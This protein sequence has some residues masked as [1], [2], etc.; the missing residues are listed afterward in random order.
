M[1][2]RFLLGPAGSGKTHHC[3]T[4]LRDLE[5]AGLAGI[6]LVPE[7]FTYSADRE[8]LE[9]PDLRG[10]RHVR[11]LSFTRL[12]W[13]IRE[14]CGERPLRT[15]DPAVRPMILRSVMERM[16][17]AALGPLAP[18]RGRAGVL[19][20]LSRF[21][22]EVRN[23]GPLD[24]FDG[25]RAGQ[26]KSI[27]ETAPTAIL[28]K[29][30]ALGEVYSAY[31]AR[32]SEMGRR[33]PEEHLFGLEPLLA[34]DSSWSALTFYVDGFLSWTRREVELLTVLAKRDARIEIA[35]CCDPA[36][37]SDPR[38][39][40]RPVF[41]SLEQ[42]ESR[43]SR[44]GV[45]L[46]PPVR[47]PA[48]D[49]PT[50]FRSPALRLLERR[51]YYTSAL[52]LPDPDARLPN[53][54]PPSHRASPHQPSDS[55]SSQPPPL[56]ASPQPPAVT[57][58][59]TRDRRQEVVFWARQIDRWIRLEAEPIERHEIAVL[60]RD[61]E[62][63]RDLVHEIFE[64]YEIPYFIDERR[65]V[66]AHPRVRLLLGALDVIVG[67]WRRDAVVSLLR[68]P[69]LNNP[70]ALVDL[71]ENLSLEFGRDYERWYDE[72]WV[73]FLHPPRARFHDVAEELAPAPM[74]EKK[75]EEEEEESE[76]DVERQVGSDSR[77][78][79]M[80]LTEPIRRQTLIPLSRLERRW[81]SERWTGAQAANELASLLAALSDGSG[82]DAAG[83]DD[84]SHRVEREL[85]RLLGEL[86]EIWAELPVSAEELARTL[87][88]GLLALRLGLA[89][90]RHDQVLVGDV[91]RSRVHGLRRVIAG[92]INDTSFPRAVSDDPV[93]GDRDRAVLAALGVSLGPTAQ[94]RQEE[95]AYLFYIALTR[96]SER[97]VA[98]WTKLD[99][100]GRETPPSPLLVELE[101]A[102]PGVARSPEVPPDPDH[103]PLASLQTSRELG[104]K[105][106]A[107]LA[108]L[109]HDDT[110]L[111][112]QRATET[113]VGPKE[114]EIRTSLDVEELGSE[115]AN[116]LDAG[117]IG[118]PS[119]AAGAALAGAA[120]EFDRG[121]AAL[122]LGDSRRLPESLLDELYPEREISSSVSRLQEFASCPYQSF[123]K[124]ILGLQPRPEAKVTPLETGTLAHAALEKF[125]AGPVDAV[126]ATARLRRIFDELAPDPEYR[127][128]QLDDASRF[129]WGTTRRALSRFL[130][131]E[132]ARLSLSGYRIAAREKAFGLGR[133][134][135]SAPGLSLPLPGGR[136]LVL[137]GQIDRIDVREDAGRPLA[138]VIDYKRSSRK[139][140]PASLEAGVDL[141]LAAYLLYVR[142][143]EGWTPAG[144]LYVPVVPNPPRAEDIDETSGNRLRIRAHGFVLE[145][146][147]DRIDGGL[148]F[149]AKRSPQ[150]IPSEDKLAELLETGR[151][152][153]VSYAATMARGWIEPRPL[154][155]D[156]RLPCERCDFGPVCRYRPG[157]DPRRRAASEGMDAI[158]PAAPEETA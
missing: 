93:L 133:R 136:S 54:T 132:L 138:L 15:I 59:E 24:F 35:L 140:L 77:L 134:D 131:M 125:F 8:L 11:V 22:G 39:P 122:Y 90:L 52:E 10:L 67:E 145:N 80:R 151:K 40:F 50:R 73:D 120:A 34:A 71:L 127:G 45:E 14:R 57:L 111:E 79:R 81:K 48:G 95:E 102:I 30:R 106:L 84:W 19:E 5:R 3:L 109:A 17:P 94:E 157:K 96:A 97:V 150:R 100:Q 60:L 53:G 153:L 116:L 27:R 123:A 75:Q 141:Q 86:S 2:V 139:G 114:S 28:E 85:S 126:D 82:A 6:Y 72:E 23:H 36:E 144:G 154:L 155:R 87:R 137:R 21:V 107:R 46:L 130:E 74:D 115:I 118:P 62:P 117:G 26:T 119:F 103:L 42:L 47:F 156:S 63:Y 104:M 41:R 146:E 143:V 55:A 65:S 113:R 108:A 16:D 105:L 1:A 12:A 148:D 128:F 78:D 4:R 101:E 56:P 49:H 58:Q 31:A 152:Y 76:G 158:S 98:T 7:Q 70:P 149:L 135:G 99:P 83:L 66:L 61:V 32:L 91:Q 9:P 43:F 88:E 64:R 92:G 25:L 69:L 142:E 29:L 147:A 68:N 110:R 18:M 38:V 124:G 51:L 33:D 20:Q 112:P 121:R 89:P 44:A 37:R 13:W 129:R